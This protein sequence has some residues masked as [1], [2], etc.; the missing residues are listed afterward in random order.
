[1]KL[2][3]EINNLRNKMPPTYISNVIDDC[4]LHNSLMQFTKGHKGGISAQLQKTFGNLD[5]SSSPRKDNGS[6]LVA[7]HINSVGVEAFQFFL[8]N[9]TCHLS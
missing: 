6:V 2:Y 8:S 3:N 9:L 7:E 1:M 5:L 4:P